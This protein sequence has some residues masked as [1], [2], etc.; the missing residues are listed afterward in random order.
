MMGCSELATGD[1][2]TQGVPCANN[3]NAWPWDWTKTRWRTSPFGPEWLYM[4]SKE[5]GPPD[6][7]LSSG[8]DMSASIVRPLDFNI[9]YTTWE[10]RS[11]RLNQQRAY[12]GATIGLTTHVRDYSG[13]GGQSTHITI[14]DYAID[15]EFIPNTATKSDPILFLLIFDRQQTG[16]A[17]SCGY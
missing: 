4:A 9:K 2:D 13:P 17:T 16:I 10:E 6:L 5:R 15:S 8:P 11:Q 1:F 7:I 14:I 12:T 3:R